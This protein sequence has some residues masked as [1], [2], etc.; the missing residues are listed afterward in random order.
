MILN[1]LVDYYEALAARGAIARPGWGK[2]KISFALELD[3]DG[4]LLR[5]LPLRGD[6]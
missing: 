2:T 3:G 5:A 4:K 1:A 6:P